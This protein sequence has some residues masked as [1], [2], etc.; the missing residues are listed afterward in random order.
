MR[1]ARTQR[2]HDSEA[3]GRGVRLEVVEGATDDP[4]DLCLDALRHVLMAFRTLLSTP[5]GP[6]VS[7]ITVAICEGSMGRT[8]A[9]TR[10]RGPRWR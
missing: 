3:E 10:G 7:R 5:N 4:E 1:S 6:D 9:V 8:D 2:A